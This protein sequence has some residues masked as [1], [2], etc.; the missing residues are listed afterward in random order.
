MSVGR[1][2]LQ[3]NKQSRRYYLLCLLAGATA[4]LCLPPFGLVPLVM[5]L[6]WPALCMAR[7]D[8]L[9]T[10]LLTGWAAGFGWF[11]A[12]T[13][14]IAASM[15]AGD[16]G[17]WPL[18][19]LAVVFVPLILSL[20]W[21][22]AAGLSWRLGKQAHTRVL[23]LVVMLAGFEWA[24]G[25]VA[26]GFPWNAPGYLF[27]AH[28]SLLQAASVLGLYGLNVVAVWVAM[29]PA[30]WL[31][32]WRRTAIVA[33]AILPLVA[34]GGMA[35][36]ASDGASD[37]VSDTGELAVDA[38][39]SMEVRPKQVR[40]VQPA[41]PQN[42]KWDRT[43][44]PAHLQRLIELSSGTLPVPQ[45]VIWPETA[46]AGLLGAERELFT[47]TVA[48]A[49]PYDGLL[50]TGVPRRHSR[51]LLLNSAVLVQP[52]GDIRAS[53]DKQ[54]LVPFG[55]YFPFRDLFPFA[56][57]IVG[58]MDYLHGTSRTPFT[59]PHYGL[60]QPLICYEVIFPGIFSR[61][62]MRPDIL[63]N[64]TND[65]WFGGT[66]GPYQHLEQA[67]MRAVE[68]GI[69]LLRVANTGV[70]AGFDAYGRT[71]AR[72][73][74]DQAGFVDVNVPEPLA[75]TIYAIWRETFLSV[76]LF[77]LAGLTIILDR[78]RSLGQ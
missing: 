74:M 9:R 72:I 44:R 10:A 33:G 2:S 19:P 60:V 54:K 59:L 26:T 6:S 53:Y 75:P 18:L 34:I 28:L 51:F 30:F 23:W 71:L 3:V 55:E 12:S 49:L 14:W 46:F 73:D 68:E 25:F 5:A 77:L 21:A 29:I 64:L 78:K 15:V 7:T 1:R 13:W 27:S 70:S 58:P 17:H 16:T 63:V 56:T 31:L 62:E 66:P 4:S 57:A 45:L 42:E 47:R 40:L 61:A 38:A 35:R 41:V 20:F 24:R 50:V 76:V 52:D 69:P 65:A 8:R 39:R 37:D 48:S 67:R 22:A 43:K 11:L 32:G 36:L